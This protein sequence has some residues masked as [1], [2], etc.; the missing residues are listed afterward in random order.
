MKN[1][2]IPFADTRTSTQDVHK[3]IFDDETVIVDDC[4]F[5]LP[6]IEGAYFIPSSTPP[7]AA[8]HALADADSNADAYTGQRVPAYDEQQLQELLRRQV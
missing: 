7:S 6:Y 4:S 2:L 1:T 8:D 3:F 5:V